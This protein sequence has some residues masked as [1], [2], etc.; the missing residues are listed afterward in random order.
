MVVILGN[1][2]KNFIIRCSILATLLM[3]M[4]SA[5]AYSAEVEKP[6][7][8]TI[9]EAVKYF[10]NSESPY[11]F[12]G[13]ASYYN[14]TGYFLVDEN[15]ITSIDDSMVIALKEGQWLALSNRYTIL[16][17]KAPGLAVKVIDGKLDLDV[18]SVS[19]VPVL[20]FSSKDQLSKLA[21][22][23]DQLRYNHLWLPFSHLSRVAEAVLVSIQKNIISSWGWTIVIFAV[24]LKFLLLPVGVMTVKFQRKVSQVQ[25]KLDPVLADIKATYDGEEAHN[26][27]MAAHKELGV[28]PFYSLKPMLAFF[29]QIPILIAVFNA[30][31]EMPQFNQQSFFWIE[32]L[33]YPDVVGHFPVSLLM[34]GDTVSILPVLMT[35]VTIYSTIIFQNSHASTAEVR[36]Q[37][38]NLYLMAAAFFVLFYPFPAVM[39][40]Y[41][42]LANMLHIIQQQLIKV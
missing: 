5:A 8:P 10:F 6:K 19:S 22:E 31:G 2:L 30:L 9:A 4:F 7:E 40:F 24:L 28:S 38:R 14:V 17:I 41:W 39:V 35:V 26:R 36:R 11:I 33:A 42:A 15:S 29:I 37:K 12:Y 25:S 23:L 21:P 1:R 3:N 20:K 27:I 34:F 32:N 18:R 16:A 13:L